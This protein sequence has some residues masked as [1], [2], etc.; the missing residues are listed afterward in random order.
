[1]RIASAIAYDI[2][3]QQRHGFYYAYLVISLFYIVLLRILP[4]S[5]REMAD[6]IL[7]FTDPSMLGFFFIGGLV[8]LEKGQDIHNTLFVTPYKHEEYIVSKTLSLTLLSMIS[9]YVIHISQFGLSTNPLL[10]LAG[11]FLT[12]VFFTLAGMGVAFRCRSLNGFFFLSTLVTSVF[13]L[14]I[15]DFL[16]IWSTPI[17][18]VLPTQGSF[19]LLRSV[20]EPV[21]WLQILYA[22]L[23]LAG[24]GGLAFLWTRYSFRKFIMLRMGGD[25]P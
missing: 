5:S 9:S 23:I 25:G 4:A 18:Y 10:F 8:L 19:M 12:S 14:P 17:Y 11:V 22:V 21:P 13:M 15:L 24:W 2:K 6:I 20:F 16:H 1:M 3:L 7:T